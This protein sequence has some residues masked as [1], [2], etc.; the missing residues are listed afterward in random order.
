MHVIFFFLFSTSG[1]HACTHAL[2]HPFDILPFIQH[3][4]ESELACNN[5]NNSRCLSASSSSNRN[6]S[7]IEGLS[8]ETIPN[9]GINLHH[10]R[11][12][13]SSFPATFNNESPSLNYWMHLIQTLMQR[14]T[15]SSR[16]W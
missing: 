2:M 13:A 3:S 8:A 5:N 1:M 4:Q 6:N 16:C 14:H 7:N 9:R 10:R 12:C 11:T 15:I